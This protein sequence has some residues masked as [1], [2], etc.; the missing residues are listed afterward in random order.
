MEGFLDIHLPVWK[1][2]FVTRCIAVL[3][4]LAVGLIHDYDE[5]D[6]YLNIL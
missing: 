1:R 4:A 2:V 6:T 3:P 5:V